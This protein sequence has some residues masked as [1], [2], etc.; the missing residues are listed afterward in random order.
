MKTRAARGV[1]P[2]KHGQCQP[3]EGEPDLDSREDRRRWCVQER[4]L[5]DAGADRKSSFAG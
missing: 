1:S 4:E 5:E 2:R 3:Q